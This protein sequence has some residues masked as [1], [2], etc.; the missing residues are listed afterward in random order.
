MVNA[1]KCHIFTH[2]RSCSQ[3]MF[4][5]QPSIILLAP[6]T[7]SK[8]SA[9][10]V[11]ADSKLTKTNWDRLSLWKTLS[12]IAVVLL[13]STITWRVFSYIH[14]WKPRSSALLLVAPFTLR[15]IN[16]ILDVPLWLKVISWNPGLSP[17]A[18]LDLKVK[19]PPGSNGRT[20][21]WPS[22]NIHWRS[23]RF[24]LEHIWR[25]VAVDY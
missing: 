9:S 25:A 15:P 20:W 19:R 4:L 22:F 7:L 12:A 11:I 13:G 18:F 3:D 8:I 6:G 14:N 16:V 5:I 1:R 21:Y 23:W 10:L 2:P 17:I 24:L